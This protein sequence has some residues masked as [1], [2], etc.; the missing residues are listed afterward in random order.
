VRPLPD[1]NN[2]EE[3]G[4]T[5]AK[6]ATTSVWWAA[7]EFIVRSSGGVNFYSN[8]SETAGVTLAPGG[9]MWENQDHSL[10]WL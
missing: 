6:K 7:D 3:P 10:S 4:A 1:R 5:C 8:E 2:V 9:G